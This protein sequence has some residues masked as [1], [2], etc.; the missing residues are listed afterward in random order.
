MYGNDDLAL[1][2]KRTIL[3]TSNLS[4]DLISDDFSRNSLHLLSQPP[5]ALLQ[6][7]DSMPTIYKLFEEPH[8]KIKDT[9]FSNLVG[10]FNPCF[11]IIRKDNNQTF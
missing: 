8:D 11:A 1:R 10:F 2:F 9:D 7:F 6:H 3:C 4:C 5:L